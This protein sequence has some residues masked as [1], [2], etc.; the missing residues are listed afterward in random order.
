MRLAINNVAKNHPEAVK[1]FYMIGMM[2]G[3]VI[4]CKEIQDF[5]GIWQNENYHLL[6]S[7]LEDADLVKKKFYNA[8]NILKEHTKY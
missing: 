1:L 8:N 3:G 7:K 6:I 2:P 5:K 4:E